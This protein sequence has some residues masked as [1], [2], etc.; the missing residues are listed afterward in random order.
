MGE[1]KPDFYNTPEEFV[2]ATHCAV[3]HNL[4][5]PGLTLIYSLGAQCV[6]GSLYLFIMTLF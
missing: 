3:L 6:S 4:F 5:S 2:W 1:E